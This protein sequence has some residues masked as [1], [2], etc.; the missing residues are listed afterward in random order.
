MQTASASHGSTI[1]QIVG[2]GNTVVPGHPHLHLTRYFSR[3]QVRSDLDWLAPYTRSTR[4]IGRDREMHELRALLKD[5]R[6]I[7]ARVITGSGGRGKTRLALELCDWASEHGWGAGFAGRTEMT[8]FLAQQN[9]SSWGWQRPTLVVI[10]YAAQHA[11]VLAPWIEELADR[12]DEPA[13]PLRLLLLERSASMQTGWCADVFASGGFG[14]TSTRA[15]L[16]PPEPVELAPLQSSDS[17][18]ALME[19]LLRQVAPDRRDRERERALLK[20]LSSSDFGGDPL[21]LMMLALSG[22]QPGDAHSHTL[23]RADLALEL[24]RREAKRIG[25]L[26]SGAKVDPRLAIHLVAC[27][28]LAQGMSRTAFEA[29]AGAEK[30][31]VRRH[32]GGDVA[33]LADVLQQALP[34]SNAI[35]PVLPDLIGEAFVLGHDIGREAVLRCYAKHS[36]AVAR[37]AIRCAQDFSPQRTEPLQWLEAISG[38]IGDD[39]DALATLAAV[40]PPESVA[41]TDLCLRVIQRLA[42][43]RCSRVDVPADRR[44]A[45]LADLAV[46]Q[47]N[48]G[49]REAALKAAEEAAD[50][51]RGL[52]ARH[53]S[54]YRPEL[55]MSLNNLAIMRSDLGQREPALQAAQEA[56]DL[57]RELAALHPDVFQPDLASSLNN[58]ASSLSDVGQRQAALKAAQEA[59]DIRR[60]LATARPEVFR[61]N[62]ATSLNNLANSLSDLGQSEAALEAAQEATDLYRELATQRPDVFR[63]SLA[64]SLH[65]LALSL[66]DL[67]QREGALQAAQEA[68]DFYRELAARHPEAFEP[69]LARSLNTL[70]IMHSDLGHHGPALKAAQEAADLHRELA[71]QRPDVFGPEL[72]RS[73]AVLAA[74]RE[75]A[76]AGGKSKKG[77]APHKT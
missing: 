34:R 43:V 50:L 6:P 58:L 56:A 29:F 73:L 77:H 54:A 28:T 40:L 8:R 16:D 53:L 30:R 1:I 22:G 21:Y 67:G 31:A 27:V 12:A 52:A 45:A 74:C 15:L 4:L 46:A 70:A 62:L 9:L 55:A 60:E 18:L 24:A 7:L 35:A 20:Q 37:T 11:Q 36:M 25:D 14:N 3:R 63:P 5:P 61:P 68:G 69:D 2:D 41:L 44:A 42:S 23:K 26:A 76:S 72:A 38:V 19:D 10:D 64:G 66:K 13:Q 65:N 32:G 49:H 48:A 33:V 75:A 59:T 51:Y 17:R 71:S 57:Y 39:E 47:A